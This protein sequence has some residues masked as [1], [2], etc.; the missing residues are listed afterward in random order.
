MQMLYYAWLREQNKKHPCSRVSVCLWLVC[1]QSRQHKVPASAATRQTHFSLNTFCFLAPSFLRRQ[2]F[3]PHCPL[4]PLLRAET[5]QPTLTHTHRRL[6]HLMIRLPAGRSV[7]RHPPLL[8]F[9]PG[10]ANTARMT[11]WPLETFAVKKRSR[12]PSVFVFL[13]TPPSSFYL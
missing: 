6:V 12:N 8:S 10:S 7:R 4:P 11:S 3:C 5:H 13:P 1:F 2:L 9:T